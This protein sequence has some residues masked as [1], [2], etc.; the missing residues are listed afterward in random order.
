VVIRGK[1]GV[2]R[3]ARPTFLR[4]HS[5]VGRV[6][7]VRA[8]AFTSLGWERF[9]AETDLSGVPGRSLS[10]GRG[11]RAQLHRPRAEIAFP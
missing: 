2:Q 6:T 8:A 3:T 10:A 5:L 4:L 9:I 7:P 1:S 11:R